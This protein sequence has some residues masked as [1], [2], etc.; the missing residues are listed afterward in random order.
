MSRPLAYHPRHALNAICP[1]YTMF[2]LEYPLRIL[3]KHRKAAPIVFDPFCGRGTTMYA[4]RHLGL[5]SWGIDTS[6][7]AVAIARAKVAAASADKVIEL[8]S[9]L[10]EKDPRHI[11][12]TEFFRRAYAKKTLAKLCALREGLLRLK[13]DTNESVLLRAA[14]L[15][16]LHGPLNKSSARASY[17]SNQMP[18]T[19]A[20]KPDYS[21]KYWKREKLT[22]PH[23]DI[24]EVL[25]RKLSRIKDLDKAPKCNAGRILC[26]DA[27]TI[28]LQRQIEKNTSLVITSPPYYGMRTYVEDQWLR[29]WFLGGPSSIDYG[30]MNQLSHNGQETFISEL[31]NVW[32]RLGKSEAARV[33]LYVRFGSV[34]CVKSDAKE[35]LR[36]SLEEA[37][38]WRLVSVRSARSAHEGKRQ[39]DQMVSESEADAEYDF[40]AIRD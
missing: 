21:A 31:A 18:R 8:A 19:F 37:E 40:H 28:R 12:D 4:A 1:Y 6:P 3:R 10:I 29:M 14:A 27:R 13:E 11:P 15:G 17:F 39:A 26:A 7:I 35:I 9:S 5:P 23:V 32:N 22:A 2:P 25:R 34:P 30:N 36:A 24:V 33:D 20:T 38:D 16:C